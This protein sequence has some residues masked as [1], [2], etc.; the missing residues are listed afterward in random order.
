MNLS[1]SKSSASSSSSSVNSG[2]SSGSTHAVFVAARFAL[3]GLPH[4]YDMPD[5][6]A[7]CPHDHHHAAAEAPD[8][9]EPRLA[10]LKPSVLDRKGAAREDLPRTRNPAP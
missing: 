5:V 2:A 4:R 1:P 6:A 3:I 7:R 8:G 9:P 10:V